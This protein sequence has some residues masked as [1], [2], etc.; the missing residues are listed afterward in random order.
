MAGCGKKDSPPTAHLRGTVTIGGTPIPPQAESRVTFR[1]TT[2]SQASPASAPILDGRF[3]VPAAPRGP[4]R[5]EF[6]IQLPIGE[7]ALAP[8]MPPEMQYRSLV[9]DERSG[10]ILLDVARDDLNMTLDL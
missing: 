10:G 5:A 6:S 8:G 9:P 2:A 4:V 1:A 3:D 7:A